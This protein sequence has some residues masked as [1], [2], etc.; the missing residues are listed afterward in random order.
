MISF[1]FGLCAVVLGIAV[2]HRAIP[3]VWKEGR[4]KAWKVW[5]YGMGLVACGY[6]HLVA[7]TGAR[8]PAILFFA[9]LCFFVY[10]LLRYLAI[11]R[12][13]EPPHWSEVA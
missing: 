6:V 7:A 9:H 10:G 5:L 1:L 3:A 2:W 12:H 11:V 8:V 13:D 4:Q